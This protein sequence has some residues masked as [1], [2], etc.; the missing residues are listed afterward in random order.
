[1]R[2]IPFLLSI[3]EAAPQLHRLPPDHQ[4]QEARMK[5]RFWSVTCAAIVL[6]VTAAAL[7]QNPP[8]SSPSQPPSASG[9]ADKAIT[10]T[11]CVQQAKS[12][13]TGT[14]GST[15]PSASANETKFVLTNAAISPSGSTAGT[16]GSPSS[17]AVASEYRLDADDAKLTSHVGHKVEITGT[18]DQPSRAT[19]PPAA[20]AANAPKLKVDSVKM[21]AA[22]CP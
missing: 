18:I 9:G 5:M 15:S 12:A 11:G 8:S 6:G 19:Q 2:F 1:V 22:T 14:T 4:A 16:A 21:I 10:V 7:A 3:G 17:T 20:S 13:P